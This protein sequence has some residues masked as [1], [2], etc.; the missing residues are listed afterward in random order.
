[1]SQTDDRGKASKAAETDHAAR[2]AERTPATQY[3]DRFLSDLRAR[4][5]VLEVEEG[6]TFDE[7]H[8]LPPGIRWVR[9]PNGDLMRVVAY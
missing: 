2:P 8:A 7:Q 3:T 1:M 6:W 9:Y 4:H 5:Q